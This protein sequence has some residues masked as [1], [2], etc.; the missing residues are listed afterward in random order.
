MATIEKRQAASLA[1]HQDGQRC[2]PSAG[3]ADSLQGVE[4]EKQRGPVTW[5][6]A[7]RGP[8]HRC[9]LGVLIARVNRNRGLSDMA[10]SGLAG[11][12]LSPKSSF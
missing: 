6:R 11:R 2:A 12:R 7:L 1:R 8:R 4:E 9:Q 10:W 5:K 3:K